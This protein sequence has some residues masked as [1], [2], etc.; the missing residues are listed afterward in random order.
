MKSIHI[1]IILIA[2]VQTFIIT[3]VNAQDIEIA[4]KLIVHDIKTDTSNIDSVKL[5]TTID[6]VAHQSAANDIVFNYF[7]NLPKG[8][9][10]LVDAGMNV[11][12]LLDQGMTPMDIYQ[13]GIPASDIYGKTYAG[14]LIFFI[15][16]L[17][18]FPIEGM[19][20]SPNDLMNA[21]YGCQDVDLG[22]R[23]T[24]IGLGAANTWIHQA[25]CAE[26]NSAAN[27]CGNLVEGGYDDWF[28]PS[29]DELLAMYNN[30][31]SSDM[32]HFRIYFIQALLR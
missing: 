25:R 19:V 3:K 23:G 17:D 5:L 28:L 11:Q 15:D 24:A 12:D 14:G 13:S 22:L 21:T 9:K 26:V 30:L 7:K 16:T 18:V 32:D 8:A 27:V 6:G 20:A 4:G 29:Y 10:L 2:F 31:Y 1:T